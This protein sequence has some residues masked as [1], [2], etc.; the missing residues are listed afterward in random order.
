LY[1]QA[2]NKFKEINNTNPE[3]IIIYRNS[4]A[5]GKNKALLLNEVPQLDRVLKN[6][7]EMSTI[8]V[9]PSVLYILANK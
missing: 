1:E 8:D 7:I 6:L 3:Q 9:K 2:I 4:V 5:E